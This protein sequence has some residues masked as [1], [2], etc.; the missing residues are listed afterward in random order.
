[1]ADE[2]VGIDPFDFTVEQTIQILSPHLSPEHV[3]SLRFNEVTGR[4]LLKTASYDTLKSELDIV[5]LGRRERIMDVV[6]N[7][8]RTSVAYRK[9]DRDPSLNLP[10]T[11]T[12][13]RKRKR[14]ES[15]LTPLR[16][17]EPPSPRFSTQ[18]SC[19][20]LKLWVG[21]NP[22]HIRFPLGDDLPQATF[23]DANHQLRSVEISSRE[24]V[25]DN[26][27]S[28]SAATDLDDASEQS[29]EIG[30]SPVLHQEDPAGPRRVTRYKLPLF[31][32]MM[33]NHLFLRVL[34]V[35][36]AVAPADHQGDI[37]M[38]TSES[39]PED[40]NPTSPEEPSGHKRIVPITV[41]PVKGL[42]DEMEISES[43]PLPV[44]SS[45]KGKSTS[46]KRYLSPKA[47]KIESLFYDVPPGDDIL[48]DYNENDE[49]QMVNYG[50]KFPGERRYVGRRI[51]RL[52]KDNL[53]I[54]EGLSMGYATGSASGQLVRT[55]H[56]GHLQA[57]IKHYDN[58]DRY[59][60]KYEHQSFTVFDVKHDGG[61]H[62]HR[63]SSKNL[64]LP[65]PSW[66][67]PPTSSTSD[68]QIVRHADQPQIQR[69]IEIDPND[70]SVHNFDYLLKWQNIDG[71]DEV[72]PVFGESDDENEYDEQTWREYQEEFGPKEKVPAKSR[73]VYLTKEE[74]EEAIEEGIRDL[75][76]KWREK[77]LPKKEAKDAYRLWRKA[78]KQRNRNQT[79]KEARAGIIFFNIRIGKMKVEFLKTE[80]NW[81]SKD[82]V[83]KQVRGNMEQTIYDREDMKWIIDL[84]GRKEQPNKPPPRT[85]AVASV[86]DGDEGRTDVDEESV[87]SSND[88]DHFSESDNEM[89]GFIIANPREPENVGSSDEES[90]NDEDDAEDEN[91]DAEDEDEN[92][93]EEYE[94]EDE[95]EVVRPTK[96]RRPRS[97]VVDDS[98]GDSDDVEMQTPGDSPRTPS[99]INR[100][101]KSENSPTIGNA[102]PQTAGEYRIIDL[103][104]DESPPKVPV[105]E[106]DSDSDCATPTKQSKG[107][108]KAKDHQSESRGLR[109]SRE[110]SCG[111]SA[112]PVPKRLISDQR[113]EALRSV[114]AE[115]EA[116]KYE[117]VYYQ[118]RDCQE[119]EEEL[120]RWLAELIESLR[121]LHNPKSKL[122]RD[123]LD[124]YKRELYRNACH[125]YIVWAFRRRNATIHDKVSMSELLE[126]NDSKKFIAFTK[127]LNHIY[128]DG[129]L[130]TGFKPPSNARNGETVKSGAQKRSKVRPETEREEYEFDNLDN[131]LGGSQHRK[132]KRGELIEDEAAKSRRNNLQKSH[133]NILRRM[134]DHERKAKKKGEVIDNA[135][136]ILNRGHYAK[137]K[138][139]HPHPE[140]IQEKLKP[141][142]VEGIRFLWT[143][144]VLVGENGAELEITEVH[145]WL[146]LWVWER[147]SNITFL[148]TL[149]KS[150]V[151]EEKA[152]Y[153]QIPEH[154]RQS[155][156][157]ILSPP[158]LVDN[159]WD[160]FHNWL[161]F[162]KDTGELNEEYIGKIYRAD[163]QIHL[164]ERL[165]AI[166]NWNVNGGILLLGYH[167][168]RSLIF[169]QGQLLKD[170]EHEVVK[171]ILLE[172][173]N[174]I[175]AD[176]AHHLKNAAT[177]ITQAAKGFKSF[178][179]IAMT[180]SP[181]SNNL[182][183]YWSMIEWIDPGYLGPAKEFKE[184]YVS[185]ITDGLYADSSR[186]EKRLSLKMLNV[187]R[188]DISYKI[189]RADID[190]IKNDMPQKTE[191]LV[192]VP[193][194]PLQIMVYQRF[195]EDRQ[196]KN[197]AANIRAQ[198]SKSFFDIT[199]LLSLICSHPSIF[200][201]RIEERER[202]RERI[203]KRGAT[204]GAINAER[205]PELDEDDGVTEDGAASAA[206]NTLLDTGERTYSWARPLLDSNQGDKIEHSYKML[207]FRDILK[208]SRQ[209]GDSTL[210]F[211]HS[212]P[213]LDI[214][215]YH[216]KDMGLTYFR[217]DGKTPMGDRQKSAKKFNQEEGSAV[218]LVSTEAGGL[219]L[220]LYGANRVIIFDFKWSPTWESQAVGRAYRLG[221]TKHVF[222]YRF[223]SGG[224]YEDKMWNTAQ[225]KTQL[226]SRVVD[227]KD[228]IREA[229]KNIQQYLAPPKEIPREDISA[230]EGKDVVLDRVIARSREAGGYICS[231]EHT[232][233]F[234]PDVDDQ[235]DEDEK[236]EVAELLKMA[237]AERELA[238][239]EAKQAQ[240]KRELAA[241]EAEALQ[242][243]RRSSFSFSASVQQTTIPSL[244]NNNG[245]PPST[246]PP[247][248]RT[249]EVPSTS[250]MSLVDTGGLFRTLSKS[251]MHASSLPP[252]A[253]PPSQPTARLS[254]NLSL[255]IPPP[256]R[257][258]SQQIAD[259]RQTLDRLN[260]SAEQRRSVEQRQSAEQ[261][262]SSLPIAPTPPT[263]IG[264]PQENN[265]NR[266]LSSNLPA[267][268]QSV[269]GEPT[270]NFPKVF[271]GRKSNGGYSGG[272]G[273]GGV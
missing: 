263:G 189:N 151:S 96:R 188:H 106:I 38:E 16:Y 97:R 138:D 246:M 35:P 55:V 269:G 21:D 225:F 168:F 17:D 92:E 192:I 47:R 144:L 216:V 40:A 186:E 140:Y 199:L 78:K 122:N 46:L 18:L 77:I 34:Q 170:T 52:L 66:S 182:E 238:D 200:V 24:S 158:G 213:T 231:I 187:L 209:E 259:Q 69:P 84:M 10:P 156:T 89:E 95:D 190:V 125:L 134:I 230:F 204:S 119:S 76:H 153:D 220:N 172:G 132:R 173:P 257:T 81:S 30:G 252:R 244:S 103:T 12:G 166:D 143:Q 128:N 145:C 261:R 74:V 254:A 117:V 6:R 249:S 102:S 121:Q 224:T 22:L 41:A 68:I 154:L 260:R 113:Y 28:V 32:E 70:N 148:Y 5:P 237:R 86:Q 100:Q 233:T 169:N 243:V 4:V 88:N 101:I 234:Q 262:R 267:E 248:S 9:S 250:A 99:P 130:R 8:K 80:M 223:R 208:Y 116:I 48:L 256:T 181:L 59:L 26:E 82:M 85:K 50:S 270:R 229:H 137:H 268:R 164:R 87:G 61:V 251:S 221:Q 136:M 176:E 180:G 20:P 39:E 14:Q 129:K 67:K 65:W 210:V 15:P 93:D 245:A 177:Q 215:E 43:E 184:K 205:T 146:I 19:P 241:K 94:D 7:L 33:K 222:V 131:S 150:G 203:L 62:V 247:P 127:D 108:E 23:V 3:Q 253:T 115:E 160:E 183:E 235:L 214:L 271:K 273:G 124:I 91:K 37:Y 239:K 51:C 141:H 54:I 211:S 218:F 207:A 64:H 13:N 56:Q 198:K 163:G 226:Q 171:K 157:L 272:G 1:M 161:P 71:A 194:T 197:I 107:K 232:E 105:I 133:K 36:T 29:D 75:V 195:I 179:R 79:I 112:S 58:P 11:P 147:P 196:T 45:K 114:L 42:D 49:F 258:F 120:L 162:N 60:Q 206:L 109:R 165:C 53:Q 242:I 178:S 90:E 98:D 31:P 193:L 63:E 110:S 255:P 126:L 155:K 139:I 27:R 202:E 174:V 212:I 240:E 83:R 25:R 191:F 57:A 159:W 44:S 228:P 219:G 167:M 175:V 142:Q 73:R 236:K 135:E 72:L 118:I 266:R 217:L 264:R 201:R 104:L 149:A 111:K 227:T 2:L 123:K 185:P 152:V 265:N